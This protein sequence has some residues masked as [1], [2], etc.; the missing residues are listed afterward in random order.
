MIGMLAPAA[1]AGVVTRVLSGK[2][3]AFF[4]PPGTPPLGLSLGDTVT[5]SLTFEETLG[6]GIYGVSEDPAWDLT[7]DFGTATW[8]KEDEVC[9]ILETATPGSCSYYLGP[10]FPDYPAFEIVDGEIVDLDYQ[11]NITVAGKVYRLGVK[12]GVLSGFDWSISDITAWSPEEQLTDDPEE[13]AFMFGTIHFEDIP[14]PGSA[15]LLILPLL[16]MMYYRRPAILAYCRQQG[17]GSR[18]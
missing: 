13:L 7:F 2:F 12:R 14:E 9:W 4:P 16:A 11:G 18:R 8:T 10:G 3:T 17:H 1:E 15:V 5:A 6:D